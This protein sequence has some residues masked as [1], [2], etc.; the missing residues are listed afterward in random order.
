MSR[1]RGSVLQIDR[2]QLELVCNLVVAF[3]WFVFITPNEYFHRDYLLVGMYLCSQRLASRLS[4]R[5]V[6]TWSYGGLCAAFNECQLTFAI[7]VCQ[8]WDDMGRNLLN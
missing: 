2:M 5:S 3:Q 6:S 4:Y 8:N 7:S 1:K